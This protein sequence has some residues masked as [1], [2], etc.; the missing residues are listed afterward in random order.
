MKWKF[1]TKRMSSLRLLPQF[2]ALVIAGLQPA[3]SDAGTL[4]I[5]GGGSG[6]VC[7][8]SNHRVI[9][10]ELLDLSEAPDV[11]GFEITEST[12]KYEEQA[13]RIL[14]RLD[15]IYAGTAVPKM[16]LQAVL[17]TMF[18]VSVSL[19]PNRVIERPLDLGREKVVL[20]KPGCK[21]EGIGY[22]QHNGT[23][24][25]L[26]IAPQVFAALS[27]THRAAFYVHEA[28]YSFYQVNLKRR[29]SLDRG[30]YD[31]RKLVAVLFS[32]NSSLSDLVEASRFLVLAEQ[33]VILVA[34]SSAKSSA[35]VIRLMNYD[36]QEDELAPFTPMEAQ[37]FYCK[38]NLADALEVRQNSE[39]V[40]PKKLGISNSLRIKNLKNCTELYLG[41]IDGQLKINSRSVLDISGLARAKLR[42]LEEVMPESQLK[43]TARYPL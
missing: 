41:G 16:H 6:D 38:G 42:F 15:F 29:I 31:V 1:E 43:L 22:R 13:R 19:N 36:F 34:E 40:Q 12:I 30:T 4:D 17:Q 28:I 37:K 5:G 32:K 21:I 18:E 7:R 26:K 11:H 9:S 25:E 33:A 20:S 23:K 24:V 2:L 39:L 35:E 27:E 8:D 3:F 14:S 10:A